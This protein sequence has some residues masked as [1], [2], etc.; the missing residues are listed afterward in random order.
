MGLGLDFTS[1]DA[2]AF[3]IKHGK[4][5]TVDGVHLADSAFVRALQS[6][7]FYLQRSASLGFACLLTVCEGKVDSLVQWIVAKLQSTSN[8]VWEM[9]L[10]PLGMLTRS[11]LARKRLVDAGVT[12]YFLFTSC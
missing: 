6:P 4:L 1:A 2:D 5:F 9:A 3:G 8:G 12:L 11:Q 7:D 10:P